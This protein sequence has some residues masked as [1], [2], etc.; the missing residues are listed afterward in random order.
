MNFLKFLLIICFTTSAFGLAIDEKLSVRI[1]RISDSRKTVLSNRGLEDGLVVGDHAKFFLSKGVVARGVV[2]KASPTRSV[3]SMYRV[4]NANDLAADRMMNLKISKPIK[5]SDDSSKMISNEDIR[6]QINGIA[7]SAGARDLPEES[8]E[9]DRGELAALGA[10]TVGDEFTTVLT[11]RDWELW[12]TIHLNSLTTNTSTSNSTAG[13]EFNG[14]FSLIDFSLGFEIYFDHTNSFFGRFSI[15]PFIHKARTE[16][17]NIEG[18]STS[19][20]ILEFGAALNWHFFE[21]PYALNR[22]IWFFNG[23]VGIGDAKDE[24]ANVISET[25]VPYEGSLNFYS[26]GLGVKYYVF[27][28]FGMR[29]LVDY[30]SRTERYT[31][32]EVNTFNSFETT[33]VVSGPRVHVGLS[34]RW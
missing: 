7:L 33:K 15:T 29:M 25:N 27:N 31:L 26:A 10:A 4:I 23:S 24:L 18:S 16:S 32:T 19:S 12:T 13:N 3:W 17:T 34:Y 9:A 20:D 22:M 8:A 1:L 2:I 28:G 11:D 21:S 5:V 14:R 30:Y 6:T